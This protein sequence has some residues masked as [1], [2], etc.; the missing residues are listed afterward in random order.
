MCSREAGTT[1]QFYLETLKML[2]DLFLH[3]RKSGLVKLEQDVEEPE[4]SP[5]FKKYPNFLKDH[6]ALYF[7]C[8]T[9]RMSITGGVNTHELDQMMELD[10]D[11]HHQETHAGDGAYHDGRCAARSRDCGGGAGRC[12]YDGRAGRTRRKKS[13]QKVAAALVG[14]FLGVLLCY[15]LVGPLAV[16]SCQTARSRQPLSNVLRNGIIAYTRGAPPMLALEF[17]RRTIPGRLRPNFPE[18]EAFLK[19]IKPAAADKKAGPS[20]K[21]P[22]QAD[23][24]SGP[25]EQK[26]EPA[27]A[28][29]KAGENAA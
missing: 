24:K 4:K 26:P 19:G 28:K 11:V 20:D 25:A 3:A 12:D 6:H 14:T 18:T 13:E 22:G 7:V 17:A 27:G 21:K 9:L 23:K 10:I 5:L 15:G 1:R 29:P 16:A 2:N 8:D